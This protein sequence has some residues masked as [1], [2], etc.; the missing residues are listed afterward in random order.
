M[1]SGVGGEV[2]GEAEVD[3]RTNIYPFNVGQQNL[4]DLS[5][6]FDLIEQHG[7]QFQQRLRRVLIG[8][9]VFFGETGRVYGKRVFIGKYG[10]CKGITS[11]RL[12]IVVDGGS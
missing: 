12:T 11:R 5:H 1:E 10:I 4:V 2:G 8:Q 9:I 6:N 7:E 3:S